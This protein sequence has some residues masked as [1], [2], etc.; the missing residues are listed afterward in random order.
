MKITNKKELQQIAFNL[1]SDID[2]QDFANLHEKCTAKS[3]SLSVVDII[4]TSDNSSNIIM[5]LLERI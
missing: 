4:L 5:N 1:S 3:Y 2:F